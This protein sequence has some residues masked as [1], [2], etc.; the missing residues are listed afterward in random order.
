MSD[1]NYVEI[2]Q[3]HLT[4]AKE[5]FAE[6]EKDVSIMNIL[7]CLSDVIWALAELKEQVQ[8]LR[9]IINE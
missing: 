9:E 5:C 3:G 2:S 8:S 4:R 6:G 7:N 1:R